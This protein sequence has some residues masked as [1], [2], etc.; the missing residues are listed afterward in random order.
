[1]PKVT[2]AHL[3]ARRQQILSAAAACFSRSG[4]HRTTMRDIYQ[5]AHLSPGAVYRYFQSKDEIIRAMA[6][7]ELQRNVAIIQAISSQGDTIQLL[8]ELVH[9]FFQRLEECGPAACNMSVEVWAEA[10]RNPRVAE[11]VRRR[12]Q[13]HLKLFSDIIPRAQ[14]RGDIDPTLDPTAVARVMQALFHGLVIQKGL[15]PSVDIKAYAQVLRSL[16][17]G[18]FWQGPPPTNGSH[19]GPLRPKDSA[20]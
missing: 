12:I 17:R 20:P 6:D 14:R 16:Y 8:D 3:E 15:D 13:T 1:M 4:F 18:T 7:E 9:T 5:E 19:S 10:L 2:E 11:A